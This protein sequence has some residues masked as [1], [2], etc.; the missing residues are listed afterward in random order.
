[1]AKDAQ[2]IIYNAN[3]DLYEN[4]AEILEK[5]RD[6][7]PMKHKNNAYDIIDDQISALRDLNTAI[8]TG[9]REDVEKAVNTIFGD[10]DE[11]EENKGIHD[12]ME[13]MLNSVQFGNK[14]IYKFMM[15]DYFKT[16]EERQAFNND[17]EQLNNSLGINI[18]LDSIKKNV[19]IPPKSINDIKSDHR[20][21][22][23]HLYETRGKFYNLMIEGVT[24]SNPITGENV[25]LH[26]KQE[27]SDFFNKVHNAD[28]GYPMSE[29]ARDDCAVYHMQLYLYSK[30]FTPD[31]IQEYRMD[32]DSEKSKEI[33]D[34]IRDV[35]Q[36]FYDIALSKDPEKTARMYVDAYKN[37]QGYDMSWIKESDTPEKLISALP[38]MESLGGGHSLWIQTHNQG[39]TMRDIDI[40]IVRKINELADV[41]N[42]ALQEVTDAMQFINVEKQNIDKGFN[43]FSSENRLG[44]LAIGNVNST[45][46][47]NATLAELPADKKITLENTVQNTIGQLTNVF[48]IDEPGEHVYEAVDDAFVGKKGSFSPLLVTESSIDDA[49][50]L[51]KREG[52]TQRETDMAMWWGEQRNNADRLP[53]KWKDAM[54]DNYQ[55]GYLMDGI[56]ATHC[57]NLAADGE[58]DELTKVPGDGQRMMDAM[59]GDYSKWDQLSDLSKA[60][61]SARLVYEHPGLFNGSVDSMKKEADRLGL[62]LDNPAYSHAL[63]GFSR[64]ADPVTVGKLGTLKSVFAD[65]KLEKCI[66]HATPEQ[67]KNMARSLFLMQ[68]GDVQPDDVMKQDGATPA[69]HILAESGEISISLPHNSEELMLN[70]TLPSGKTNMPDGVSFTASFSGGEMKIRTE[71]TTGPFKPEGAV[72][73]DLRGLEPDTLK[74]TIN[75]FDQKLSEMDPQSLDE[76]IR[77]L[78]GRNLGKEQMSNYLKEMGLDADGV[79]KNNAPQMNLAAKEVNPPREFTQEEF[80][81]IDSIYSEPLSGDRKYKTDLNSMDDFNTSLEKEPNPAVKD[82]FSKFKQRY[83]E[84]GR[85]MAMYGDAAEKM[86]RISEANEKLDNPS[87]NVRNFAHDME[88][89]LAEKYRYTREQYNSMTGAMSEFASEKNVKKGHKAWT[90][91]DL[92]NAKLS[93]E[94]RENYDKKGL[95]VEELH[96]S[97]ASNF[98][99]VDHENY[100]NTTYDVMKDHKWTLGGVKYSNSD[101][102]D[103][104]VESLKT[105]KEMRQND[106]NFDNM[107]EY[108]AEYEHLRDLCEDY[109]VTH[110]KNP[111]TQDGKDRLKM[112]KDV[113]EGMS[114]V[115]G[116]DFD[117][118]MD[119][120]QPGQKIGE[121]NLHAGERKKVSLSDLMDKERAQARN[122]RLKA[123]DDK[124]KAAI[125][126]RREAENAQ[127]KNAGKGD[128]HGV[129]DALVN[130]SVL[131]KH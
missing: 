38:K 112:V 98:T 75:A 123:E 18:N 15:E 11:Y 8:R 41:E 34:R 48:D 113:W 50:G 114:N 5:F 51:I 125:R 109:I 10:E 130:N 116:K 115:N 45:L 120:L 103:K 104:I 77:H 78:G 108:R 127:K 29:I 53:D 37:L 9:N 88:K 4:L 100:M 7:D 97:M 79:E 119:V 106:L 33:A 70:G 111:W 131:K 99:M 90:H 93:K 39:T 30:G 40:Q 95:S 32:P 72:H 92:N 117:R 69:M 94:V 2:E 68:L 105:L 25:E 54:V 36:G 126:A 83:E 47:A 87:G 86:H 21:M 76:T 61:V 89:E 3:T 28:K 1:M 110:K 14:S 26:N 65:E 71:G 81:L 35:R 6:S 46:P 59:N 82:F 44:I 23:D 55:K 91:H 64:E 22:S 24:V 67:K 52:L 107:K 17:L 122:Q 12:G 20:K 58:Y 13:S 74:N 57:Y 42:V 73:A 129:N 56:S 62:N 31:E 118:V 66:Q 60:A 124:R 121:V 16:A 27:Y 49:N 96:A 101:R 85:Q 43:R 63:E 19:V 128:K 80:Q 102:Y 84:I